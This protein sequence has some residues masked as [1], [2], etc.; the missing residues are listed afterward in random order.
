MPHSAL[1]ESQLNTHIKKQNLPGVPFAGPLMAR[2][3]TFTDDITVF[4]SC[5]L[6]IKAVKKVV[7]GYQQ[8]A[9]A[10]VAFDK[11]EGL[12]LGAC[13]GSDPLPGPFH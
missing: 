8:I 4:V 9:G 6:D 1:V 10:K 2:V 3:S 5:R 7:G 13:R 11:S 12:W